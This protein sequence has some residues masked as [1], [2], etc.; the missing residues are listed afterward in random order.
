M[1]TYKQLLLSL[2]LCFFFFLGHGQN[3]DSLIELTITE[4][5]D[6]NL[7]AL[8]D[9]IGWQY[10]FSRPDSALIYANKSLAV[11]RKNENY[12]QECTA[13]NS[14]GRISKMMGNIEKSFSNFELAYDINKKHVHDNRKEGIFLMNMA[15]IF[16]E[17]SNID[18]ALLLF[19]KAKDAFVL[20]QDTLNIIKVLLNTG[21]AYG[22]VSKHQK[23]NATYFEALYLAEEN[24]QGCGIIGILYNN[25]GTIFLGIQQLEDAEKY[26]LLAKE[27]YVSVGN[28]RATAITNNNLGN[29]Y[30]Q[31]NQLEKGFVFY[32]EALKLNNF[33]DVTR[34]YTYDGLGNYY[35]E[36]NDLGNAK[37]NYEKSYEINKENEY[38][39]EAAISLASIA[40]IESKQ[41]N[42]FSALKKIDESYKVIKASGNVLD[43]KK[44]LFEKIK[45]ELNKNNQEYLLKTIT[46]YDSLAK[47][48]FNENMQKSIA[49]AETK[50]QTEK[51]EVENQLLK[52]D[53]ELQATTIQQQRI[54][55]WGTIGGIGLFALMSFL[56]YRQSAER[57]RANTTLAEQRNQIETLHQELAHRVKNNLFFISTLMKM[58]GKRVESKEAKQAI[59]EGE[60]R[61]EAMSLL[62]RKLHL[63][64]NENDINIGGYL[65]ELCANL[66]NTFPYSGKQ[67]QINVNTDKVLIDG[68]PAVKIG[69]IVNEL[70]TNSFKYAFEEQEHPQINI[71]VRKTGDD[72][73]Q[74]T[75]QDNGIG[76][77]VNLDISKS[78]SM[79]LKLIHSLTK[80]LDGT[81]EIS[82]QKGAHFQ[83]EFKQNKLA[84]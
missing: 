1:G 80:Q 62:H 9:E 26:F 14:I 18:S 12:V 71:T 39:I 61:L 43:T 20:K 57:K 8:F 81:I 50:Y 5:N 30:L 36:V 73:Y 10:T 42:Y 56:L 68:D 23:A 58:Q 49:N 16:S 28:K 84:I 55:L 19:N 78:E 15:V 3:V 35:N 17:K 59:K 25:I 48:V 38:F 54:T 75:Y 69:L 40:N 51:K 7:F 77:P 67:P 41:G 29:I 60:A 47:V 52:K 2:S 21:H 74:L 64:E 44:I 6:N 31:K 45:I 13:L 83:F 33:D 70:V 34:S 76:I 37:L 63:G 65:Q 82:N 24:K 22:K 27:C 11:A 46:E 79:G 32:K 4:K 66:Q 53:K 72:A